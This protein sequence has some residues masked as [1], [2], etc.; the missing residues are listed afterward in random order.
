MARAIH[1]IRTSGEVNSLIQGRR[2][3]R[4]FPSLDYGKERSPIASV[5]HTQPE[6]QVTWLLAWALTLRCIDIRRQIYV[7]RKEGTRSI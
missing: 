7:I 3:S 5:G 6:D 2:L 4:N 1:N